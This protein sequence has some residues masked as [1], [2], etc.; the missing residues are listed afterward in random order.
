MNRRPSPEADRRLRAEEARFNGR[1]K[2]SGLGMA[3]GIVLTV[4][5][6]QLGLL[7]LARLCAVAVVCGVGGLI[8]FIIQWHRTFF[9]ILISDGMT[10][11]EA[12]W[13]HWRRHG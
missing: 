9:D 3:G 7:S 4:A 12:A 13:E 2:L 10:K 1:I 5:M 11:K 6:A 8:Y